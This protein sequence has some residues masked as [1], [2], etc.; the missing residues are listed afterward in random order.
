[1][2]LSVSVFVELV[3]LQSRQNRAHHPWVNQGFKMP[4]ALL[5]VAEPREGG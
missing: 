4:F 3:A 5:F 1:M 2:K